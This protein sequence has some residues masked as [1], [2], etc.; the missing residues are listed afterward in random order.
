MTHKCIGHSCIIRPSLEKVIAW[1][2][3][4][5]FRLKDAE[6]KTFIIMAS[7]KSLPTAVVIIS[8]MGAPGGGG[9]HR[10]RAARMLL[11][12]AGNAVV[13][14]VTRSNSTMNPFAPPLMPGMI[15]P[16]FPPPLPYEEEIEKE[17]AENALDPGL[18]AIPCIVFYV[19][20]VWGCSIWM[21][22]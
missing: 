11:G 8:Y 3:S 17:I 7:Q 13:K 4:F 16:P 1:I 14:N 10:R 22:R 2:A 18:M 19:L 21:G 20:Q 6:R 12:A 15:Q 5:F 9:H